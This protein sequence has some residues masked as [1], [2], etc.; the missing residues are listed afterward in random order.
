VNVKIYPFLLR[1]LTP[2]AAPTSKKGAADFF[3]LVALFSSSS[4][5]PIN[6]SEK[7]T[8]AIINPSQQS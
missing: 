4:L 6:Q 5:P 7:Q 3:L 2:S 1:E 8:D